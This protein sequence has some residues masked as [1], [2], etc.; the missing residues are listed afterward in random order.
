MLSGTEIPWLAR[1]VCVADTYDAMRSDRPYRAGMGPDETLEEIALCSGSQFDPEAV[2]AFVEAQVT[3]EGEFPPLE[4]IGSGSRA[5]S[6][7]WSTGS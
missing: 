4:S 1:I 7:D 3:A 2:R 6:D 5:S